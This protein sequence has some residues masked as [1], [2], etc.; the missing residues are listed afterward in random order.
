MDEDFENDPIEYDISYPHPKGYA[1]LKRPLRNSPF[2][3]SLANQ[4][5]KDFNDDDDME[6]DDGDEDDDNEN[7]QK[8]N[9]MK[10]DD[11]LQ[12]I[13]IRKKLKRLMASFKFADPN[14]PVNDDEVEEWFE[15]RNEGFDDNDYKPKSHDM[16]TEKEL[17]WQSEKNK[18]KSWIS[19]YEFA[20]QEP[21][22]STSAP[23]LSFGVRSSFIDHWT[24]EE[25][26][27]LLDVWGNQFILNERKS[28]RF[29]EWKQVAG[30]V[31]ELSNVE[32][33]VTQCRNRVDTLK[34]KYKKDKIKFEETG[35]LDGKCVYF[36]KMDRLMS[37]VSTPPQQAN[38]LDD[39]K[40][41][42]PNT[43]A[44]SVEGLEGSRGKK[45]SEVK[46]CTDEPSS[47]KLLADF[48]LKLGVIYEKMENEKWQQI[49]E[50]EKLR[51]NF[52][53]D[54]ETRRRQNFQRLINEILKLVQMDGKNEDSAKNLEGLQSEILKLVQMDGKNEDSA[55]NLEGL[56]SEILKLV[57]MDGKNEDSAK[58][59]EGLQSE[60]LKLVQMDHKNEG[61][62]K[63]DGSAKSGI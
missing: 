58:N 52:L 57:Q 61:S 23:K 47:F 7:T 45:I 37:T 34:K 59:L 14:H 50:L 10:I 49:V 27:I 11:E 56:Q 2:S 3:Q 24:D 18:L 9:A 1:N 15:R 43:E 44:I 35:S 13:P 51:M 46:G 39:M 4:S 8:S 22:Q 36:K 25:T 31:S 26:L 30:T 33:T 32:K 60:I 40:N 6:E 62:A 5:A 38:Q 54:M 12:W 48:I 28:L 21:T 63:H 16:E 17:E 19:T 41:S 42:P 20:A 29:E 55:K 53:N